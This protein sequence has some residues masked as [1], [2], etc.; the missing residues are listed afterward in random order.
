MPRPRN[1]VIELGGA[2][3]SIYTGDDNPGQLIAVHIMNFVE[4]LG[5]GIE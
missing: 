4:G 1:G 2:R 5:V 3:T